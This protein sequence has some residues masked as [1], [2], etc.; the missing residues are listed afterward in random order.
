MPAGVLHL[1]STRWNL[2][3]ALELLG[4]RGHNPRPKLVLAKADSTEPSQEERRLSPHCLDPAPPRPAPP[5]PLHV[6]RKAHCPLQGL[7][8]LSLSSPPTSGAKA[9]GR[10]LAHPLASWPTCGLAKSHNC[11]TSSW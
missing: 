1:P 4:V 5:R 2:G 8:T 6:G 9:E 11:C 7:S 10:P 3:P